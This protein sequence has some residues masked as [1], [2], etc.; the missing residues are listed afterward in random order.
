MNKIHFAVARIIA[1]M[2]CLRTKKCD[3]SRSP[4]DD[5][6][7]EYP[8]IRAGDS[9]KMTRHLDV[10]DHLSVPPNLGESRLVVEI[11]A[12]L[13]TGKPWMC[14]ERTSML[15]S[16]GTVRMAFILTGSAAP[17]IAALKYSMPRATPRPNVNRTVQIF[18]QLP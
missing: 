14:P 12:H 7:P 4:A 17:T 15:N 10:L 9:T 11:D 16:C 3:P 13:G 2:P 6:R 8:A 5:E 18:E 1:V